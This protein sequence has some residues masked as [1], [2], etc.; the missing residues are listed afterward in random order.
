M[1]S[2]VSPTSLR[3]VG[4]SLACFAMWSLSDAVM[5]LVGDAKIS[6]VQVVAAQAFFS[7]VLMTIMVGRKGD[8]QAVKSVWPRS[9]RQ[10]TMRVFLR[11][12]TSFLNA[13]A[14]QYLSLTMFYVI[15]FCAPLTIAL[16]A[17]V[18]LKEKL[19]WAQVAAIVAGFAGVMV[20]INP[21]GADFAAGSLV[22][23]V[24]MLCSVLCFAANIVWL[25][26]MTQSETTDSLAFYSALVG[27]VVFVPIALLLDG[28]VTQWPILCLLAL[29]SFFALCGDIFNFIALR[30]AP[31]ATVEQYHYSQIV[32]GAILG[33]VFWHE[34]PSWNLVV[35]AIIIIASGAYVALAALREH[36]RVDVEA[37]EGAG[38]QSEVV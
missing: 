29:M 13:I 32:L 27:T 8:M 12:S 11:L 35:G 3:A 7:L 15:A 5:K 1:N 20:A 14:L 4:F 2:S 23:V 17:S 24:A 31:A 36:K 28:P 22:G 16:L 34:V 38:Q 33:Y 19:S 6:A 18:A 10:Q 37:V 9:P 26:V 25:R 30:H 21:F